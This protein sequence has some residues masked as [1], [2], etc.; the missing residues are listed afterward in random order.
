MADNQRE[1][2]RS[3]TAIWPSANRRLRHRKVASCRCGTGETV[4]PRIRLGTSLSGFISVYLRLPQTM[5]HE[6]PQ[7]M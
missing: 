3:G 2:L 5:H 1:A 4:L 6:L 7:P